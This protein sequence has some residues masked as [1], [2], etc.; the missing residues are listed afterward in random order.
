MK[1]LRY[2]IPF[3]VLLH[4]AC[5]ND[6]VE[7]EIIETPEVNEFFEENLNEYVSFRYHNELVSVKADSISA[8]VVLRKN[9]SENS[10][11]DPNIKI[12]FAKAS[13]DFFILVNGLFN[14]E[15]TLIDGDQKYTMKISKNEFANFYKIKFADFAE[16]AKLNEFITNNHTE[17]KAEQFFKRFVKASPSA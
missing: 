4:F 3:L 9:N 16:P 15:L 2:F 5:N 10:E 14:L 6:K 8:V 13:L 17:E 11:I 1:L 12:F 7:Q